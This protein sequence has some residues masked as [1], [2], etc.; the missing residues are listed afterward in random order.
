VTEPATSDLEPLQHEGDSLARAGAKWNPT[1]D[2]LTLMLRTLVETDS[3]FS[4]SPERSTE[5]LYYRGRR[6]VLA[7]ERLTAALN[8][9]RSV[10]LQLDG[11]LNAL[12]QDVAAN[13]S[14][15]PSRFAEHLRA[16]RAKL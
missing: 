15:D 5:M 10:R 4:I 11:E 6:L 12:R 1:V 16:L 13:G 3:E 8:A 9:S 2:G 14:F 7:L